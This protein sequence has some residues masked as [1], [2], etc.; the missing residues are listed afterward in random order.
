[1][2]DACNFDNVMGKLLGMRETEGLPVDMSL[3][4]EVDNG[5]KAHYNDIVTQW[6]SEI[7]DEAPAHQGDA[8]ALKGAAS[9]LKGDSARVAKDVFRSLRNP[10]GLF[11]EE[12]IKPVIDFIT[13]HHEEHAGNLAEGRQDYFDEIGYILDEIDTSDMSPSL[14]E[15]WNEYRRFYEN[16]GELYGEHEYSPIGKAFS[17]LTHN[18]IKSSPTVVLGNVLEG[19]VKLPTLYPKTFMPAIGEALKAGDGNIFKKIPELA[20][21]GIY[22]MNEVGD[23]LGV[24]DGII[25]LTDIP[26]KNIAYFA[27][28]LADGDG[29][30]GVQRVAFVNRFGDMPSVYYSGGG[31]A[32]VKFLSYTINSYKMY[33][34]LWGA[35]KQGNPAPL[36]T[37]HALAG[38]F[39][40]GLAAGLP[41]GFEEIIKAAAPDT[42]EWFE[43]NKGPLAKVIQPG[44][45]TRLGVGYDIASK[46]LQGFGRN[47]E[48]GMEAMREGE[49]GNAGL[50]TADALLRLMTFTSSP[51]GDLNLQKI[52]RIGKDVAQ[53]ELEL[54]DAPGEAVGKLLPSLG[55]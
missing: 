6:G 30:K 24:W 5:G 3:L 17:N 36:L 20:R 47:V 39:G 53:E 40:G 48:S 51:V 25:G 49:F 12:R 2:K 43:E 14:Q 42:E 34:S 23:K 45:I 4:D 26:L 11:G 27:G 46:Q 16:G 52:L 9:W 28:K 19:A 55:E 50:E 41:M 21:K 54:E 13:R 38:L 33:A 18:V 15:G 7:F 35:L 10:S 22:D 29:W 1:M 44:N 8:E 31:R 32:A 37:Y